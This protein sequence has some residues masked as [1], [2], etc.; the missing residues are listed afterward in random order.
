MGT[1]NSKPTKIKILFSSYAGSPLFHYRIYVGGYSLINPPGLLVDA[2]K[3]ISITP[4]KDTSVE[5]APTL[6]NDITEPMDLAIN[7]L[8]SNEAPGFKATY[9]VNNTI[10]RSLVLYYPNDHNHR[11]YNI[12]V[13]YANIKATNPSLITTKDPDIVI[14][15]TDANSGTMFGPEL[16]VPLDNTCMA[17]NV[18]ADPQSYDVRVEVAGIANKPGAC[19]K[20][21]YIE[22]L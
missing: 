18:I 1:S 3:S 13:V 9:T 16:I 6:L 8:A 10:S 4:I 21:I 19:D 15:A 11:E 20:Y 5:G 7:V 12:H 22:P 2:G 14:F 17:I